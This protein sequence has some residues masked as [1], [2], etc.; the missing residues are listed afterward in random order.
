MLCCII[1]CISH[2]SS[3][4][5]C[6]TSFHL[7]TSIAFVSASSTPATRAE[8]RRQVRTEKKLVEAKQED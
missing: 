5:A 2:V 1:Y 6:V 8:A 4:V 3:N 7:S